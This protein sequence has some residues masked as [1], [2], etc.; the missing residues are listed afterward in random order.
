MLQ[1]QTSALYSSH[2]SLLCLQEHLEKLKIVHRDLAARNVLLGDEKL[3]KVSDFGL[4]RDVYHH[5]DIGKDETDK[6]KGTPLPYKWM[7]LESL[8]HHQFTSASDV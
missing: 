3:V 8:V 5:H 4:A 7:A 2:C 1:L 6:K